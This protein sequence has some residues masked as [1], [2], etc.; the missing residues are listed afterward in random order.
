MVNSKPKSEEKY[1][2][3]KQNL[4]STH[5]DIENLL[6]HDFHRHLDW[7]KSLDLE[8]IFKVV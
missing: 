5:M 4:L 1:C 8:L 7:K 6:D 3:K 2:V